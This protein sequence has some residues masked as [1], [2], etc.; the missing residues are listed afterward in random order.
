M[1]FK[2]NTIQ[3]QTY[4]SRSYKEK[5]GTYVKYGKD[6]RYPYYLVDLYNNSA[7]HSACINAITDA[8][9]G[10]GLTTED[11]EI[12][13][14]ANREGESWNDL[15][16]KV[17]LDLKLFGGFALEVIWSANREKVAEVYHVDF[18]TLRAK[19]KNNRGFIPGYYLSYDWGKIN[20][21][22]TRNVND[23]PYLPVYNPLNK[24]II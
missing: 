14:V 11:E 3:R 10:N 6:N 16:R 2:F 17:A 13:Q 22:S 1:K 23:I 18:S 24:A 7:L 5:K 9:I 12:L 21:Y 19:E 8:I 4:Q 20:E 15:L